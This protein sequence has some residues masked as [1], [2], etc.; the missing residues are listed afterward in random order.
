MK[1]KKQSRLDLLEIKV[2]RLTMMLIGISEVVKRMPD[3]HDAINKLD[4]DQNR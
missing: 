4:E 2:E 3:Y 1:S